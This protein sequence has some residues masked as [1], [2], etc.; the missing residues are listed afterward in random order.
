MPKKH[1]CFWRNLRHQT[2]TALS[3]LPP[4]HWANLEGRLRAVSAPPGVA[5]GRT[6]VRAKAGI[7]LRAR[8]RLHRPKR[9]YASCDDGIPEGDRCLH[10]ASD[11]NGLLTTDAL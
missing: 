8:T 9:S 1:L 6:G 7:P 5:S 11:S 3:R 4:L 10:D 2:K